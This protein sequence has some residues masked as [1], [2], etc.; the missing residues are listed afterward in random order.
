MNP[1]NDMLADAFPR[2]GVEMPVNE[3]TALP[4]AFVAFRAPRVKGAPADEN[5]VAKAPDVGAAL[6]VWKAAPNIFSFEC[7]SV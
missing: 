3:G 4:S 1:P 7:E 6:G 5:G 2:A